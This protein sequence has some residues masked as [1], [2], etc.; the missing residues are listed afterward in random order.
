MS[1]IDENIS[2]TTLTAAELVQPVP[3]ARPRR[4]DAKLGEF[5]FL[6]LQQPMPVGGMRHL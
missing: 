1:H 4:S 3:Y 5:F 2:F 6:R